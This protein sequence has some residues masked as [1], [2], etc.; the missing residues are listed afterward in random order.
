MT[1][2]R[3]L[4]LDEPLAGVGEQE[5][6]QTMAVIERAGRGRMVVLIEHNIDVVMRVSRRVVVLHQGAVLAQGSPQE[7][8][9]DPAVRE[10]YLG[11]E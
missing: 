4:L 9:L 7:I 2:P 5:I 10:A 11:N 8:R 1:D 6:E 3:I